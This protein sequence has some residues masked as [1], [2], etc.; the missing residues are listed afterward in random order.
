[1]QGGVYAYMCR[2]FAVLLFLNVSLKIQ[3]TM[4]KQNTNTNIAAA[5]AAQTSNAHTQVCAGN[6]TRTFASVA[7]DAARDVRTGTRGLFYCLNELNR[8]VRKNAYIDNENVAEVGR[9]VRTY[10]TNK[11]PFH[12][13]ACY[14]HKGRAYAPVRVKDERD[15]L[16]RTWLGRKYEYAQVKRRQGDDVYYVEQLVV[17]NEAGMAYRLA[18]CAQTP[19]GLLRAFTSYVCMQRASVNKRKPQSKGK[20]LATAAK[21]YRDGLISEAALGMRVAE[22]LAA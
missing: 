18:P 13:A 17:R 8:A 2:N 21:E 4:K 15:V 16:M 22:I 20:Q 1:M 5:Q 3:H 7:R 19:V 14:T 10:H 12:L 6:A 9:A 11:K